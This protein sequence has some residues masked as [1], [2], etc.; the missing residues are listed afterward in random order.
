[1]KTI[2]SFPVIGVVG[3]CTAGKSTLIR[4]LASH[5]I[6]ARHIAQEHSYVQDMWQRLTNPDVLIFL[7]VSYPVSLKRRT[8]NWTEGEYLE[9]QRR[10]R[11]ARAHCHFYLLTDPYTEEE[12]FQQVYEFL[13]KYFPLLI[14]PQ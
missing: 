6:P 4:N 12:V 11:H 1:M 9:Q 5:N 13:Q 3:P 10:L 8:F 2:K 14:P 7:D